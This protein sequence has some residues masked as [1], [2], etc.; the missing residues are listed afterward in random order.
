MS[1]EKILKFFPNLFLQNSHD[2]QKR[3]KKILYLEGI[4]IVHQTLKK[5]YIFFRLLSN[6]GKLKLYHRKDS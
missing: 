3:V 6:N 4:A 5:V 1:I 2:D